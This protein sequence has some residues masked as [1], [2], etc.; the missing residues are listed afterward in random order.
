M[1]LNTTSISLLA[2]LSTQSNAPTMPRT[3][4]I[5]LSFRGGIISVG[6]TICCL[7]P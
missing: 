1:A 6:L 2:A 7:A 5:P 4:L 3:L